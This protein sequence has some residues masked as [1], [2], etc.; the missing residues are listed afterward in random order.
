M[1]ELLIGTDGRRTAIIRGIGGIG[2]TQL[3][4]AYINRHNSDYSA[5]IWMNVKDETALKQSY[6]RAA[7]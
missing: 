7:E 1:Q 3:A 2:K 6:A 5:A 4:I